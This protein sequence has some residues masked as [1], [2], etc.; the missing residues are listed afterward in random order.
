MAWVLKQSLWQIII[1]TG[2]LKPL[3]LS[4]PK[5]PFQLPQQMCFLFMSIIIH[6]ILYHLVFSVAA[7][8]S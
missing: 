7:P 1:Q 5:R 3:Y 8:L 4:T 6:T 2:K